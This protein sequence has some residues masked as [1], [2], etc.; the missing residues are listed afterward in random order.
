MANNANKMAAEGTSSIVALTPETSGEVYM[1]TNTKTG[2]RYV[3]Q[4][5][6]WVEHSRR[7]RSY[8][9]RW[10]E[11]IRAAEHGNTSRFYEAIR[12]H[13]HDVFTIQLLDTVLLSELD[14]REAHWTLHYNTVDE[15]KGYNEC[16]RKCGRGE[17]SKKRSEKAKKQF[18]TPEARE[19]LRQRALKQWEDPEF[20]QKVSAGVGEASKARWKDPKIRE[21][22]LAKSS[23]KQRATH[24]TSDL[25]MHVHYRKLKGQIAGYTV[26]FDGKCKSFTT[27]E[28]TMEE[29]LAA[30]L[31]HLKLCQENKRK[32]IPTED[33]P[34]ATM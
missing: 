7:K 25:P 15:T 4:T 9:T 22:I 32:T 19:Q 26:T 2:H 34:Q 30:A 1:V 5:R 13:G 12:E 20:R 24:G 6:C 8:K 33:P 27:T 31:E 16:V 21:A 18:G 28:K 11:H 29:K 17:G 3:G 23:A 14:E 10:L